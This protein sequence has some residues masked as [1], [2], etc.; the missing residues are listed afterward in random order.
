M[1]IVLFVLL[2]VFNISGGTIQKGANTVVTIQQ[3]QFYINGELTYKGRYWNGH[4][5]E[6]LL[7]NS[8]MVQGVFDD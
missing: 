6:G 4:K 7:F 8:R 3:D 2:A 5:I 1:K